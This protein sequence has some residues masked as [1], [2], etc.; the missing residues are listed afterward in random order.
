MDSATRK[1]YNSTGDVRQGLTSDRSSKRRKSRTLRWD[2]DE[3]SL[4]IRWN[5]RITSDTE[6]DDNNRQ[7]TKD[8]IR[9]EWRCITPSAEKLAD[10]MTN[11]L[12]VKVSKI[13]TQKQKQLR[14]PKPQ[15]I[16]TAT[17]V[18][19]TLETDWTFFVILIGF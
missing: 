6:S 4:K 2:E 12:F 14:D 5:L 17:S 13:C 10:I 11:Q 1:T 3:P 15:N 9:A 19:P 7:P 16:E 18:T 8:E